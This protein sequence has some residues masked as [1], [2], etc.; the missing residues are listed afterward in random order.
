MIIFKVVDGPSD[1]SIH[2]LRGAFDVIKRKGADLIYEGGPFT[3]C[4]VIIIVV[5]DSSFIDLVFCS[6]GGA[7]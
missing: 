3:K 4:H 6:D 7:A 2:W 5:C 1:G